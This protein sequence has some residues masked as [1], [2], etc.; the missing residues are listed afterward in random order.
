M[1]VVDSIMFHLSIVFHFLKEEEL[2]P[3]GSNIVA[4]NSVR[5][6]IDI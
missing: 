2:S 3:H 4:I 5:R 1:N 6:R